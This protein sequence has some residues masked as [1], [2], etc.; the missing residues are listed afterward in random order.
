MS[1]Y[2][3][4]NGCIVVNDHLWCKVHVFSKTI[5][6]WY[7]VCKIVSLTYFCDLLSDIRDLSFQLQVNSFPTFAYPFSIFANL[8]FFDIQ[9]FLIRLYL[10][11]YSIFTISLFTLM[12]IFFLDILRFHIQLLPISSFDIRYL[13]LYEQ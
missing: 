1:K 2:Y 7:F 8:F 9:H 5:K 13:F 12:L 10:T 11:P 3:V 6:M 4:Y